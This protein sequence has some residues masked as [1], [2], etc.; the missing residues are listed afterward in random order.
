MDADRA[1][2]PLR[3]R[4][5]TSLAFACMAV[6]L[7]SAAADGNAAI[8]GDSQLNPDF[9]HNC[10][11]LDCRFTDL[12]SGEPATW[13]WEFGEE[14]VSKAR[15]PRHNFSGPSTYKVTLTVE[16]GGGQSRAI[17]KFISVERGSTT[18]Q[19]S[20]SI[21]GVMPNSNYIGH[22][23]RVGEWRHF[24]MRAGR[25]VGKLA[26]RLAH[27]EDSNLDL[28]LRHRLRP[29]K[30]KFRC[31]ARG[32]GTV[33]RC[34]VEAP[35]RGRWKIGIYARAGEPRAAYELRVRLKS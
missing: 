29:S 12:T 2:S 13:N 1:G 26:V 27:A 20:T 7:A 22:A 17:A 9:T 31:R 10:D 24:K 35:R 14:A 16:D 23:G 3:F 33:E 34:V 5:I 8:A 25:G 18:D 28:Y 21:V 30:R 19:D 15:N 11:G 32:D 4:L 6:G